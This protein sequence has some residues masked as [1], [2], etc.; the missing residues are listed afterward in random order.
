MDYLCDEFFSTFTGTTDEDCDL[1]ESKEAHDDGAEQPSSDDDPPLMPTYNTTSETTSSGYIASYLPL[2]LLANFQ[3]VRY[4]FD[5]NFSFFLPSS[6][7][8]SFFLLNVDQA[9]GEGGVVE[10]VETPH[11]NDIL[12]DPLMNTNNTTS[13]TTFSGY[14]ACSLTNLPE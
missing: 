1:D 6:F 9:T 7:F 14:S 4:L 12:N 2:N 8:L 13:E 10:L 3:S 5:N 11:S